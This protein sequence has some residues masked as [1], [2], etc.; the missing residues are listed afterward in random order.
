MDWTI[1][2]IIFNAEEG[3]VTPDE[4]V[5]KKKNE[6]KELRTPERIPNNITSMLKS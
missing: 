5:K 6:A 2:S 3:I 4:V 1:G